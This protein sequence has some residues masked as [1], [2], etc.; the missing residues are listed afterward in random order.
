MKRCPADTTSYLH[1]LLL[2]LVLARGGGGGGDE[3]GGRGGAGGARVE[4]QQA[5]RALDLRQTKYQRGA[6]GGATG[7]GDHVA[8]RHLQTVVNVTK[9]LRFLFC[10]VQSIIVWHQPKTNK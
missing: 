1:G 7:L 5:P 8:V 2:G 10:Y 9:P 3:G 4:D 6:G